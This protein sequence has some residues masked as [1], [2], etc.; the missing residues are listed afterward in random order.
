V[1]TFTIDE[2][3]VPMRVPNVTESATIHL[4]V[5]GRAAITAN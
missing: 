4:L 2:S 1:A 3:I 5:G